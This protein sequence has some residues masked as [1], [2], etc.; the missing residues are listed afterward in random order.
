MIACITYSLPAVHEYD[1]LGD[2]IG[3]SSLKPVMD[4]EVEVLPGVDPL[5]N[6]D[7]S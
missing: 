1:R 5:G 2:V 7:G 4:N 6:R 3:R